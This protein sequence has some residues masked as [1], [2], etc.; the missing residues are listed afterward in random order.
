MWTTDQLLAAA[1][2][3]CGLVSAAALT[4][5]AHALACAAPLVPP[6]RGLR[7]QRRHEARTQAVF[8]AIEPTLLRLGALCAQ[9]LS[10][11]TRRRADALIATASHVWGLLPEELVALSLLR[12]LAALVVG[13]CA[14]APAEWL[15]PAT[16]LGALLPSLRLRDVGKVR[17]RALERGLP[18][19]MDICILCMGAG[20][21]FPAALRFAVRELSSIHP[22]C[23][24]ELGMVLEELALGRTRVVALLHLGDRTASLAIRDFVAAVCQSEEKGTPVVEALTLQASALRQKRSILAEELAAK[25]AVRLTVPLMMTLACVML[26]LFGPFIVRGGL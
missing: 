26:L 11:E 6:A 22:V 14:G 21:D 15:G 2:W 18:A 8:R 7:G 16:A 12:T 24:E 25:T 10:T 23:T 3:L 13:W 5:L 4:P 1:P 19:A 9:R 20:A 17:A